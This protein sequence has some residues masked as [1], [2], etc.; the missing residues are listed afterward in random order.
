M[1][2]PPTILEAAMG[3]AKRLAVDEVMALVDEFAIDVHNDVACYGND[4]VHRA[5]RAAAREAIRYS[6]SLLAGGGEQPKQPDSVHLG[7]AVPVESSTGGREPVAWL[8]A[9]S[10]FH[11]YDAI[12]SRLLPPVGK[13]VPLYAD[14]MR[15]NGESAGWMPIETAPKDGTFVTLHCPL[16]FPKWDSGDHLPMTGRWLHGTPG[17]WIVVNTDMAIQRVEPANW[18]PLPPSPTGLVESKGGE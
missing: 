12:P 10:L 18:M 16:R 11:S 6:L 9:G 8:C 5:R 7:S 4:R 2:K 1:T 3:A 17:C 13:P 14:Q 15:A